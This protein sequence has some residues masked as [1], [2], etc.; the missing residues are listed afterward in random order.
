MTAENVT[1]ELPSNY[2][3]P[4]R[5]KPELKTV[6][7]LR[8][9]TTNTYCPVVV[10]DCSGKAPPTSEALEAK[11]LSMGY[12]KS[13]EGVYEIDKTPVDSFVLTR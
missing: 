2:Q 9:M 7:L 13:P 1:V 4:E 6:M 10:S 3:L 8:D 11:L 12:R 5:I